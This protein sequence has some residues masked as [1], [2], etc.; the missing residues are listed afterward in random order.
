MRKVGNKQK[1]MEVHIINKTLDYTTDAVACSHGNT[2]LEGVWDRVS[3][4]VTRL[5][6]V[7]IETSL[8]VFKTKISDL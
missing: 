5:I 6:Y 4:Q 2:K 3:L 7:Q 8:F 1:T